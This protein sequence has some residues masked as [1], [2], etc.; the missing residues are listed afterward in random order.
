MENLKDIKDIVA[1]PE[2]SVFILI[3]VIIFG[4]ILLSLVIYFF[5]NRRKRRR[6]P[7]A[8]EIALQ[9]LHKIEYSD[10]KKLV[11]TFEENAILFIDEKSQE[12]FNFLKKKLEIYKYKK[13]IPE[14]DSVVEREIKAFIK[15]LR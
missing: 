15:G 3:G 2:Y 9:K 14:L 12:D 8:K 13:D 5:K 10:T 4:V 11:Y 1:V 7:T 6:K